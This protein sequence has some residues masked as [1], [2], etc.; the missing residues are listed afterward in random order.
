MIPFKLLYRILSFVYFAIFW[1]SAQKNFAQGLC[2]KNNWPSNAVE[3]GF[4]IDGDI[5]AGCTPLAVRLKDMSGGTDIR[6]DFYYDGKAANLLDKIGNKDSINLALFSNP[7]SIRYY[8]I[9]QYGKKNGKDMYFCKTVSVRPNNKPVFSY[10]T[11]NNNSLEINIPKIQE[12][13]FDFYEINWGDGSITPEKVQKADLPFSKTKFLTLPR[14]IKVEGLFNSNTLNCTSPSPIII[15]FNIPSL[16][17]NGYDDPNRVNIDQLELLSPNEALISFHGAYDKNGYELFMKEQGKNY[18]S[19]GLNFV[20]GKHKVQLPDTSKSYCFYF[21]RTTS[22]G[23]EPSAEI[24]TVPLYS[25][26]PEEKSNNLIWSD[27]PNSITMSDNRTFGRYLDKI[28]KIIVAAN[29][30][31]SEITVNSNQTNFQNILLDCKKKVC[32]RIELETSGQLYYYKFN[33]KSISNQICVDRKLFTPPPINDVL[34]SVNLDKTNSII[35]QDDANWQ[36][37]K[38]IYYLYNENKNL[39]TKIDSLKTLKKFIDS[40]NSP[41]VQSQCYTVKYMDECGSLSLPSPKVCTINLT[42]NNGLELAW[43]NNNSFDNSDI[44]N[45]EIF[46]I[47]EISKIENSIGVTSLKNFN[48]K[49]Y[50]SA[51]ENEAVFRIKGNSNKGNISFSNT[52]KI[53][54]DAIFFVPDAFSP[55]EDSINENFEIKGRFGRVTSYNLKIYDRWGSIIIEIKDKTQKWDGNI[56]HKALNAGVYAYQLKIDLNNGENIFKN[57][58]F[59]VLK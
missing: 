26:I 35:F 15:P 41:D 27:Y 43:S 53:P 45:F 29:N 38:E 13:D 37:N 52:L 32:Y 7:N 23:S 14:T 8:T 16:F 36:L 31:N 22:C 5:S 30:I 33:G 24:C 58:K 34:V 44:I 57:G 18:Q 48:I 46:S 51:F 10:S 39:S 59:E 21:N 50:L 40:Q 25:V 1:L 4:K 11:C 20:P 6:Y 17:P 28:Q 19:I 49:D 9:L 54:I 42:S 56:K 3:G 2:D 55:N 47:D 12:N